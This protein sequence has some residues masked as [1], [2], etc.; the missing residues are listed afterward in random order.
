VTKY[1]GAV[2][3]TDSTRLYLIFDGAADAAMR[4]LFPTEKAARDWLTAGMPKIN[5]PY[6]A[7]ASEEAVSII[8][9]VTDEGSGLGSVGSFASRASKTSMWLTG[10]RSF[11]ELVY[12][13][14]ATASRAL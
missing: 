8:A 14:G 11:L 1:V 9:D 2:I 3:F 13:N 10:P 7:D 5:E 6:E 12:E 4:P